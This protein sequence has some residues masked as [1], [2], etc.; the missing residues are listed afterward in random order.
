M[1]NKYLFTSMSSTFLYQL[2]NTHNVKIRRNDDKIT[3]L[4][5]GEKFLIISYTTIIAPVFFPFNIYHILN[6]FDNKFNNIIEE[7]DKPLPSV[8]SVINN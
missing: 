7:P 4:L 5:L 6:R 8:L 3:R 1:L 2:Y